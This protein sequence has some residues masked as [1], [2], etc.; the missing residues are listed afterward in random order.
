MKDAEVCGARERVEAPF[1][2]APELLRPTY[3]VVNDDVRLAAKACGDKAL[4]TW[5]H[6][7]TTWG[8]TPPTPRLRAGDIVLPHV[9]PT[10]AADLRC[11]LDA[12]RAA[13]LEPAALV[14]HLKS[15]GLV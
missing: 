10:P 7:F 3:G 4:I 1:G 6:A 5:T 8:Q 15:A 13:G 14:R 12:A 11:A 9:T 2:R